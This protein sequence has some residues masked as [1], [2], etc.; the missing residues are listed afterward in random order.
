M[1]NGTERECKIL[2]EKDSKMYVEF[3]STRNGGRSLGYCFVEKEEI[4]YKESQRFVAYYNIFKKYQ[5][6]FIFLILFVCLIFCLSVNNSFNI[7]HIHINK[8]EKL[9]FHFFDYIFTLFNSNN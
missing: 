8:N 3:E 5:T 9:S 2:G 4:I 7:V 6:L 1:R